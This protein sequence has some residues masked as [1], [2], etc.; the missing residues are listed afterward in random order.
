MS[1]KITNFENYSNKM[2]EL[3]NGLKNNLLKNDSE[4]FN[5]Q[6]KQKAV[7]KR[8]NLYYPKKKTEKDLNI[9][10]LSQKEIIETEEEITSF[11]EKQDYEEIAKSPEI[12]EGIKKCNERIIQLGGN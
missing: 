12:E 9:K 2:D 4:E 3:E 8:F 1:E 11:R 6:E 7:N 10:L 5:Q